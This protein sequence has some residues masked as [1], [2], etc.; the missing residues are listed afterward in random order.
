VE[1]DVIDVL[2][3][4]PALTGGGR[5]NVLSVKTVVKVIMIRT[6]PAHRNQ[7]LSGKRDTT[8]PGFHERD[9]L[10][11]IGIIKSSLGQEF[12]SQK[13]EVFGF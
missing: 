13:S 5:N 9:S 3:G 7:L 4:V 1:H 6:E 10:E 12:I 8:K 2:A 11:K